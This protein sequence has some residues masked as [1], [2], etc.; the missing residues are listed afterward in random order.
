MARPLQFFGLLAGFSAPSVHLNCLRS[1]MNISSKA[2][3]GQNRVGPDRDR[4][5]RSRFND[6]GETELEEMEDKLQAVLD[7]ERNRQ[8][9]VKYD[10][11]RRKMAPSGAPQRELT[12]AAIEQI[13]YLKQEQP[14]EWTVERL[15]EGFSVPSHVILRV[16]KSKFTPSKD[17][18]AKQDAKAMAKLGQ[19]V[20]PSGSRTKE[21]LLKLAANQ[22]PAM[23][24][25]GRT[26]DALIS[27]TA[28][29]QMLQSKALKSAVTVEPP[30]LPTGIWKD[31]T[32]TGSTIDD[33][34]IRAKPEEA[35]EHEDSWDGQVL[36]EEE[37]EE[38]LDTD[39]PSPVVQMGN[40]YFDAE[41][42][43]L[44]RI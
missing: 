4:S 39:K 23:L 33:G 35:E 30:K 20:L 38:L 18:K 25:S 34:G 12:W 40:D 5:Q 19:Q 3:M 7:K 8:R 10:L 9:S 27:V 36:T 44:Y 15:A 16:L 1:S 6:D 37:L 22:T 32:V 11:I 43:F 17:R 13:R 41:G 28:Q 24:T 21:K 42:N 31:S 2:W 26:E 14:E 29:T